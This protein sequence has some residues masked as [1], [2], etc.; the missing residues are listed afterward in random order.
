MNPDP[1]VLVTVSWT[2][3]MILLFTGAGYL[4]FNSV[5]R[6]KKI[7]FLEKMLVHLKNELS[8][9]G[10][11]FEELIKAAKIQ[12]DHEELRRSKGPEIMID[13]NGRIFE[14]NATAEEQARQDVE[15]TGDLE[16]E[17]GFDMS[18]IWHKGEKDSLFR[19]TEK[20]G[21]ADMDST[22]NGE[23]VYSDDQVRQAQERVRDRIEED[24]TESGDHWIR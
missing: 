5:Q 19:T 7:K 1:L 24:F 16:A 18:R 23:G 13:R 12:I 11:Y 22:E 15:L 9:Q 10:S 8:A 14:G 6:G 4:V 2:I 21:I 20:R 17:N 3:A